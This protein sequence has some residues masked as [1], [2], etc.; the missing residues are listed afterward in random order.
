MPEDRRADKVAV[1][2]D[3]DDLGELLDPYG[4]DP[5]EPDPDFDPAGNSRY[6]GYCGTCGG[7]GELLV[8]EGEDADQADY[9]TCFAC[10]GSGQS[11]DEKLCSSCRG[12]GCPV[13]G[14]SGYTVEVPYDPP[15]DYP[16][17]AWTPKQ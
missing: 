5:D 3:D 11:E 7:D 9:V 16:T 13:C 17:E 4:G 14:D 12:E 2:G 15:A 8:Q 10:G 1:D 6:H